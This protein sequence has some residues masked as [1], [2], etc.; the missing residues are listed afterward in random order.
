MPSNEKLTSRQEQCL[1]AIRDFH[2]RRR[3][4]PT[5]KELMFAMN[6]Q[7]RSHT[8]TCL[9]RLVA[10][11]ALIRQERYTLAETARD[12]SPAAS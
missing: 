4:I 9:S 8:Q 11:G 12:R 6:T 2:A 5:V 7:S 10:H 3:R 1:Q